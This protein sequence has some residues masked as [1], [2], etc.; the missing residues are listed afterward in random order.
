[1]IYSNERKLLL[2]GWLQEN[3]KES[4]NTPLKLQKSLLL[5]EAFAKTYQINYRRKMKIY[6]K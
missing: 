1:M 5:Y 2:S 4:Y 3:N 6:E